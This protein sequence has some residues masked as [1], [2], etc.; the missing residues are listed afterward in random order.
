MAKMSNWNYSNHQL[1][2][3]KLQELLYLM[4]IETM[5]GIGLQKCTFPMS[6]FQLW[7]GVHSDHILPAKKILLQILLSAT[8][9][10]PRGWLIQLVDFS[11][12]LIGWKVYF[13]IRHEKI[14]K[15]LQQ[16]KIFV[17][18][19]WVLFGFILPFW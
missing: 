19:F 11:I 17:M 14:L 5:I 9:Q 18:N 15:E 16:Y 12:R 8:P 3:I 7:L 1:I 4:V 2:L 10:R 13:F 6:K